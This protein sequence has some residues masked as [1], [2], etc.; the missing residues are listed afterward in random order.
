MAPVLATGLAWDCNNKIG[1]QT[2]NQ[3]TDNNYLF[4]YIHNVLA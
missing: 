1:S 3:D 2:R 4:K